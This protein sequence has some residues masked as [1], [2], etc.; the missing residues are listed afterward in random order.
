M[1][2]VSLQK[3]TDRLTLKDGQ[4][5]QWDE[6]I[7]RDRH[8]IRCIE[9]VEVYGNAQI[10][11]QAVK[12][13]LKE[14]IRINYF[15]I[16]GKFLGR[17]E[18]GYPKNIR[19]RL[20]QYRLYWEPER[21]LQWS[22]ALIAAKIQGEIVEIRRLKEHSFPIPARSLQKELKRHLAALSGVPTLNSLLGVE[23]Q[24]AKIYY[25]IFPYTLPAK[26]KWTGRSYHPPRDRFNTLLSLIYGITAQEIRRRLEQRSLDPHCGFFH[27]PGYGS[28]GL[29]CDLLEAFRAT[30]CDHLALRLLH[31]NFIVREFF[32]S[33][34]TPA[35]L[36]ETLLKNICQYIHSALPLRHRLQKQSPEE[37]VNEL[38]NRV[39][40]GL[41]DPFRLPEFIHIHPER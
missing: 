35:P 19:R 21:R 8:P 36:P 16:Y 23:G 15:N 25:R 24:C 32:S 17:A 29:A 41:D 20:E 37:Q 3:S 13:C 31:R 22:K 40:A 12:E 18:P 30:F 11:T 7:I 9:S 6:N 1:E 26:I 38:L 39:I 4:L 28:G 33:S 34:A 5:I 14:G 27:E 2:T 10:T